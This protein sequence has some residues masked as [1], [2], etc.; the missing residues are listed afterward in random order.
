MKQYKKAA[1]FVC[2][3]SLAVMTACGA[4]DDET[5]GKQSVPDVTATT[6]QSPAETMAAASA[7]GKCSTATT[8]TLSLHNRIARRLLTAVMPLC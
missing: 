7:D 6:V 5:A 2:A 3:L 4:V 1:A 8:T